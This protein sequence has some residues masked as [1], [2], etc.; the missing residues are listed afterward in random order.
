[1]AAPHV[2]GAWGLYKQKFPQA[3]LTTALRAFE[4]T[5]TQVLD[6]RN[7][8]TKPRINIAQA[9]NLSAADLINC[10]AKCTITMNLG[11]QLTLNSTPAGTDRFANWSGA[12]AGKQSA[13]TVIVD[14]DTIIGSAFDTLQVS[15]A[16]KMIP[17]LIQLLED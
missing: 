4:Q 12:C 16:K 15:R 11:D 14:G 1:M 10:G 3:S 13:C 7:S 2:A 9:L 5:C 8:I 6:P 17:N